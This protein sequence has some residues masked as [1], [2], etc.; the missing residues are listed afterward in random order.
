MT[1]A[2]ILSVQVTQEEHY[3]RFLFYPSGK[4]TCKTKAKADQLS[5]QLSSCVTIH[6]LQH[7]TSIHELQHQS[8]RYSDHSDYPLELAAQP[9]TS[10]SS[11][12]FST[13][14]DIVGNDSND[15]GKLLYVHSLG[16]LNAEALHIFSS[17]NVLTSSV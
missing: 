2:T 5:G 6:G 4:T 10:I 15:G 1:D 13:P 11:A 3:S 8:K 16:G 12:S 17:W 14:L 7:P 9:F